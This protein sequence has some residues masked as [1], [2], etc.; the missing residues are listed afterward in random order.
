[1]GY[2]NKFDSMKSFGVYY[3]YVKMPRCG[4]VQHGSEYITF[5]VQYSTLDGLFWTPAGSRRAAMGVRICETVEV[6]QSNT[7]VV[8]RCRYSRMVIR[9][10]AKMTNRNEASV[11]FIHH[12]KL[13]CI[14][15]DNI[16][17]V[18]EDTFRIEWYHFIF[19]PRRRLNTYL[20]QDFITAIT[21]E[22]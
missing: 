3:W 19:P 8:R 4:C 7:L 17:V 18:R 15:P 2:Y 5:Y 21:S 11:W 9:N 1:M 10:H 22:N 6:S 20:I 14:W 13:S 16:T 12:G